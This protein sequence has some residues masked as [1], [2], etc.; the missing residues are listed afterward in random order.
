M[1]LLEHQVSTGVTMLFTSILVALIACLALEEKIHAKK[2]VIAVTFAL[3][4]LF[5]G[6][7]LNLIP[8]GEVDWGGHTISLPVFDAK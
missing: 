5:V 7:A 4:C 2:S 8:P 6:E 1:P 3:L